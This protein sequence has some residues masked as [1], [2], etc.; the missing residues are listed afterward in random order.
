MPRLLE[1]ALPAVGTC[2]GGP[3]TA[4][5][6]G[7]QVS[8]FFAGGSSPTMPP[9]TVQR[10]THVQR[11]QASCSGGEEHSG[12]CG[13]AGVGPLVWA[14]VVTIGLGG[15]DFA[16]AATK[17]TVV[18]VGGAVAVATGAAAVDFGSA[19]ACALLADFTFALATNCSR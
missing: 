5:A 13:G 4:W 6:G 15:F 1:Q 17:V 9:Q 16:A 19:A 3:L 2:A 18:V 14:W 11:L 10:L 8:R 7:W 12:V